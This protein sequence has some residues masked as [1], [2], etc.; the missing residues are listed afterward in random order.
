MIRNIILGYANKGLLTQIYGQPGAGKTN[1][2]LLN[3]INY[4]K[5]GKV[6]YIDTESGLSIE[7]LKQITENYK[8]VLKNMI[9]YNVFDFFEQDKV[10]QKELIE[11]CKNNISLV[12]V[13]NISSLYRLELT[14]KAEKN[15]VLNRMLGNQLKVL[16]KI[17]KIYNI[18]VII[19]NQI[20]ETIN[21]FEASGGHL[22]EYW[23]KCIIRLEKL[24]EDRLAILEKHLFAGEDRV[25]FRIVD[26]G[27]V[28]LD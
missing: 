10:I 19:T 6:V 2:C 4:S 17:A 24:G 22:L 16:A 26:N 15:I 14:D 3:T 11:I 8:D 21:G 5:E 18:P 7:R 27:I 13:D 9:I 23:S 20:R 28:I 25:R 12:V 1:I